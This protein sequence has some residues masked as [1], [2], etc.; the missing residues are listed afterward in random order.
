GEDV[1]PAPPRER[2]LPQSPIPADAYTVRRSV[3]W[4]EIDAAQHVNNAVYLNYAQ[5]CTIQARQVKGW[6]YT[7]LRDLGLKLI[8]HRHQIEYKAA[9]T[10]GDEVDISTWVSDVQQDTAVQ[11][12]VIRRA[13]DGKLVTRVRGL[14]GCIKVSTGAPQRLPDTFG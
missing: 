2:Q 7:Q 3:Q 8:T 13:S 5:D 12:V 4:S 6:S 9:V 1:Q 14:I 11:H 10:L